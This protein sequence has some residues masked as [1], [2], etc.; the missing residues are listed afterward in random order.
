MAAPRRVELELRDVPYSAPRVTIDILPRILSS[1]VGLIQQLQPGQYRAQDPAVLA[2]GVSSGDLARVA[3]IENS[4][5][6]GGAGTDIETA[7]ASTVG[8]AVERYCM[9]WFD[10]AD[11]VT[12]TYNEFAD[13][14]VRPD[15]LRL[16]SEQQVRETPPSVRLAYFGNDT[17]ISWV[18][19]YSLTRSR[20]ALVPAS[21]VYLNY[22]PVDGETLIGRNTSTGLAAGATLEEAVL[23]GLTE[24]IER[25]AF[26]ISWLR[27]RVG[28]QIHIDDEA[29]AD[30]IATRFMTDHPAVDLRIFDITLDI[31]VPCVLGILRRPM[32]Y[33]PAVC[34]ASVTRTSP[35]GAIAKC[36]REIG[37]GMP[38]MRYL[39]NQLADWEPATDHS[40]V[41]TFDHHYTL[42]S[43]RPQLIERNLKFCNDAIRAVR[44]TDLPDVSTGR[45]LGDIKTLV[46]MLDAI[47]HEVLA[48]DITTPDVSDVGLRVVRVLVPGLVPLHGNHNFPYLGV[49]RL[50]TV[51]AKL[52]WAD[53][54]WEPSSSIN[55]DPHPFP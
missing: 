16:Y 19:A 22:E 5:K 37:Q 15:M 28:P 9:Y 47:G 51:P 46:R 13:D 27:R 20:P 35:R 17:R 38:Y 53:D 2:M 48:L 40:D 6:A 36:V 30:E 45:P 42:Y 54:G 31:P 52:R 49:E 39:R 41:R 3:G 26:T 44:L 10:R 11:F 32:E 29:L 8:E 43:K 25:D 1:K 50:H 4:P 21:F 7:I 14:A 23:S 12:G 33:G 55:P 34:V 24:V 18:W